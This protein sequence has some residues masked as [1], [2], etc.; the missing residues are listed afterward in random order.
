MAADD[1]SIELYKETGTVTRGE[2]CNWSQNLVVAAGFLQVNLVFLRFEEKY[3]T[4]DAVLYMFDWSFWKG[5]SV[6]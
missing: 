5:L 1:E 3:L 2:G 4:L 6:V